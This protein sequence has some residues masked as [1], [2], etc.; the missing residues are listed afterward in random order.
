MARWMGRYGRV[1][2]QHT[3]LAAETAAIPLAAFFGDF[4]Q[5]AELDPFEVVR[6]LFLKVGDDCG[7]R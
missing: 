2:H 7:R 3:G 6:L 1:A 5:R 4:D